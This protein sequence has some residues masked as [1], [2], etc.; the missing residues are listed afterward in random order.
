V[1]KIG[2]NAHE[3]ISVSVG[4]NVHE[5]MERIGVNACEE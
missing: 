1:K 2:V 5:G 3:G 4:I